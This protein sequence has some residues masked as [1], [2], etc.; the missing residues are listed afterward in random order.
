MYHSLFAH[1][2]V[3]AAAAAAKSLQLCPTL[4]NPRD[5]SPPGSPVPGILQARTLEWVAISFYNAWKWEVKSESEVAQSCQTPSDPMDC[6]P[7]GSSV[8]GI[9]QAGVLEWG[10]IAF[11]WLVEKHL[12]CFPWGTPSNKT[13]IN[14]HIEV[15]CERKFAFPCDE[16]PEGSCWLTEIRLHTSLLFKKLPC[17]FSECLLHSTFLPA[18]G[19]VTIFFILTIFILFNCSEKHQRLLY[20]LHQRFSLCGSQQTMENS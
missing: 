17:C 10:A 20:W 15:L 19:T 3:A 7:P 11:S 4:C 13:A 16:G 5:G 14:F 8:H 12:N 1:W 6:S 2:L 9:L 18:F